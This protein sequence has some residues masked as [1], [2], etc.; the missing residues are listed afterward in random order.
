MAQLVPSAS[1]K[2]IALVNVGGITDVQHKMLGACF[3]GY[4]VSKYGFANVP[5]SG[6]EYIHCDFVDPLGYLTIILTIGSSFVSTFF[7]HLNVGSFIWVINF[8]VTFRNKFERGN[9]EFVLIVGATIVIEQIDPFHVCLRF[10]PTHLILD[11]M[12]KAN[13][14]ELGTME[15]VVTNI[16]G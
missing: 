4:I 12:Q 5:T 14:E 7:L 3:E 1:R 15:L 16:N 9:W 8:G 2:R 13:L 11:F 6:F 10:V